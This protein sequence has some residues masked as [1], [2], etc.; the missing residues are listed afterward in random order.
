MKRQREILS[1]GVGTN[2]GSR[3]I[4]NIHDGL[5]SVK[6][7]VKDISNAFIFQDCFLQNVLQG[8]TAI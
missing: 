3:V 1:D 4:I 6:I 7:S 8:P 2:T 5:H